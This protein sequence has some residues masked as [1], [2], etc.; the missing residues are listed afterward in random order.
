MEIELSDE[1]F[2]DQKMKDMGIKFFINKEGFFSWEIGIKPSIELVGLMT[3]IF[4]YSKGFLELEEKTVKL[5]LIE[6]NPGLK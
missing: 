5:G 6:H 3:K 4:Q 1:Q 2:M